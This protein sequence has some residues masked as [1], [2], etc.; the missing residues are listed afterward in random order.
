LV[1][2]LFSAGEYRTLLPRKEPLQGD[3]AVRKNR[4]FAAKRSDDYHNFIEGKSGQS[5]GENRCTS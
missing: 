3:S 4:R 2:A 1:K 5:N